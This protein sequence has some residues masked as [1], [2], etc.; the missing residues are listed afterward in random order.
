[1]E[2]A[3]VEENERLAVSFVDVSDLSVAG[4]DDPLAGRE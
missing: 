3:A 2:G 4:R 1:M